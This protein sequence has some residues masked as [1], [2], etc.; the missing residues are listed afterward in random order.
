MLEEV[1]SAGRAPGD[2][3][4]QLAV[5]MEALFEGPEAGRHRWSPELTS[6]PPW[7]QSA[8]R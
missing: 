3:A 5:P 6:S 7:F 2:A 4:V 1:I 8:Q